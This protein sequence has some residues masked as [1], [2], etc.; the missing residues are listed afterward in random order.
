MTKSQEKLIRRIWQQYLPNSAS[1]ME[2]Y[3][4]SR[5]SLWKLRQYLMNA[6]H[7]GGDL[8]SIIDSLSW[9]DRGDD[10]LRGELL[11]QLTS[12]YSKLT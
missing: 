6:Q 2:K 12:D 1:D 10:A 4:A 7:E 8:Q 5:Q 9:V 3:E 11:G